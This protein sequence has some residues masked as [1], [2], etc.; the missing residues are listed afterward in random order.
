MLRDQIGH[1]TYDQMTSAFGEDE[2]LDIALKALSE[3]SLS[4]A[5]SFS[6]PMYG[7][8]SPPQAQLLAPLGG[9][10]I[11]MC[12]GVAALVLC[13]VGYLLWICV[14]WLISGIGQWWLWLGS[15][16]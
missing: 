6:D 2:V 14:P 11:A 16:F 3:Q 10:Q 12:I 1:S 9:P 7:I 13:F 8:Y 4:R 15:H 5:P